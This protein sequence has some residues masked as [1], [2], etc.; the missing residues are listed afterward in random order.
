MRARAAVLLAL[1]L[2]AAAAPAGASGQLSPDEAR[3]LRAR[4][5]ER[6]V[7][8]P[9]GDGVALSPKARNRDVRLIEV[10]EG[11]IAVNGA[12]V[13]GRELRERLGE[14]ADLVLRLSYLD[15]AQ[16]RALFGEAEEVSTPEREAVQTPEPPKAPEPPAAPED[17][18]RRRRARGDRVRIFGGVH[19]DRDERVEGQ[20]VAVIGSARIDG[21]VGDQVVAVLGNV[22]LGP[23]AI[24]HGDI[25]SVGGRVRRAPGAQVRGGV[26]EVALGGAVSAED[27]RRRAWSHGWGPWPFFGTSGT[28]S[29]LVLSMVRVALLLLFASLALL[30]A[31]TTVER[32]AHR[33]ADEPLKSTVVGVV[34]QLLLLPMLVLTVIVLAI[35]LIGIPL[36]LLVPFAV[37]FLVLMALAGFAG[38]ASAVGQWARRRFSLGTEGAWA[39]LAVGVALIVLPVLVGRFVGLGGWAAGPFAFLLLA[40]GFAIEYLAWASG[41]GAVLTNTFASWQARRAARAVP[42]AAPPPVAAE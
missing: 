28:V 30:L 14:G 23:E 24:V 10:S 16:R 32:S 7:I 17:S 9:L 12:A 3:A 25:V 38:T 18:F 8:V 39:D 1:C 42:P 40:V 19:V 37:L 2:A 13:T 20:V 6:Y 31:R 41:F 35:S 34:A 11:G 33:V 22:D 5:E 29:R 4:V 21:E 36:L 15:A 26:T 27:V